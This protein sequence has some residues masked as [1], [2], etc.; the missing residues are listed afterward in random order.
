MRFVTMFPETKNIHLTKD[1]GMIPFIMY[2]KFGYDSTIVCYKNGKYDYLRDEVKGLKI[3]FIKKYTG[4]SIIDGAIYLLGNAKKIDVLH[5][6]HL[7][8]REIV[9]INLYKI[10]NKNGKV[11]LKFDA[12][13]KIKKAINPSMNTLKSKIKNITLRKCKLTSVETL[14]IYKFLREEWKI[15][16]EHI[17]NGFYDYG[18][19]EIVQYTNKDNII[20]TVGRIGSY[21]KATEILLEG[22]RLASSGL[23]NWRL[24]IVGPIEESF[25]DYMNKFIT[26]NPNLKEK[27]E[28]TGAIYNRKKLEEEYRK[29][30]IFCLTSRYEGFPLVFLEAIKH[31]CYIISSDFDAAYDITNNEKYGDVFT[32]DDVNELSICLTKDCNQ[33][34]K[35]RENCY[36]IQEYN[37]EE[38]YWPIICEKIHHLIN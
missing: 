27:I 12:D 8:K 5:L 31:G 3:N 34:Q 13:Y 18:K 19:K 6:F 2:K 28:F 23:N 14:N 26:K 15:N 7:G 30:K 36:K 20:L 32:I 29:A 4:K 22:F 37:Y 24:R 38:F 9:W 35:L 21:Q 11:Y 16:V 1:V 25:K 17:P 10:L 33:E